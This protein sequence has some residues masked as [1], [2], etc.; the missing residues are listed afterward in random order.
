MS[1]N[2]IPTE[3][4][5]LILKYVPVLGNA[6]AILRVNREWYTIYKGVLNRQKNAIFEEIL[7]SHLATSMDEGI[8]FIHGKLAYF[9]KSIYKNP[10][11][12]LTKREEKLDEEVRRLWEKLTVIRNIIA[13]IGANDP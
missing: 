12:K 8:N 1:L 6:S 3:V 2:T 4:L 9:C 10:I 7:N 5:E 11:D 13:S